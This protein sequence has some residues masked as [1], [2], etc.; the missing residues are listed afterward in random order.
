VDADQFIDKIYAKRFRN[1]G[2][3]CDALKRLLI[4]ESI[5]DDIVNKLKRKIEEKIVGDPENPDTETGSL[6]AER[7]LKLLE[8]QVND[9]VKKGAK[10]ITGGRKPD[11]LKG[12]Y[13]MPTILTNISKNMRVWN[14]EVFGPVLIVHK[15]KTE[16]EAVE[17]AND[18]KYG[19]GS[20]VFTNDKKRAH[21]VASR[22]ETGTVE[23]NSAIHWFT[24]NPFGGYKESGMG[25]EHGKHGFHEL[26]QIKVISEEK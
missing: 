10:I 8:E 22:L 19:L 23:I 6:V 26:C 11:N 25:R 15:F 17:L 16:D 14:E 13:Y 3:S 1:C 20:L 24:C 18:T 21:R 12:A 5:F 7:Q 4:H 9:A 2:Q